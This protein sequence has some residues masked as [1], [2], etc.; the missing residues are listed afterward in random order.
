MP[1]DAPLRGQFAVLCPYV[2]DIVH[3]AGGYVGILTFE[4]LLL[5]LYDPRQNLVVYV[6]SVLSIAPSL[7]SVN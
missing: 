2:R 1:S 3:L 5:I 7:L 6:C 4:R